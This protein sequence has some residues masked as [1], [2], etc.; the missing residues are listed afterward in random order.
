MAFNDSFVF[1]VSVKIM[2]LNF[3]IVTKYLVFKAG[4]FKFDFEKCLSDFVS[5]AYLVEF[6]HS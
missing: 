2:L 1:A 6:D 4:D 3:L 5:L